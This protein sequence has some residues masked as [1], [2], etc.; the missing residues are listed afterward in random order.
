MS[1]IMLRN[2]ERQAFKTCRHR[3]QWTYLDGRQAAS[4]PTALRFGDLIHQALAVYYKPGRKRGPKPAGTFERLYHEQAKALASQGF[5]VF[6]DEKWEP[7]LDLGIA[8]LEGYVVEYA[9]QDKEY[10]VI[11]SEQTFQLRIRHPLGFTFYIV[12]TFDGLWR[13]LRTKRVK[14]KEFK[15]AAAIK[16]DGLPMDEQASTYWTYGPKWLKQKGLLQPGQMPAEILYTFLRK[17]RRDPEATYNAQG[18]KLNLPSKAVLQEG[19]F[20]KT[21]RVA[22][23][24]ATV[25]DLIDAI[26]R[27]EA[28]LL[29]EVSKTQPAPFFHREPVYRDEADR[30]RQHNR[31][32]VEMA[33]IY[34]ARQP[35]A[36]ILQNIKNPGPLHM[37][38]CLGCAVREACELHEAGGDFTS[39]LNATMIQWDPYAAHELP[40]RH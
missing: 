11:S 19:Y 36:D 26:G 25:Q 10:E 15:T 37:P 38:N 29:G 17:A 28:L 32:M 16:T 7:A 8:M 24:K 21:G 5:N 6:S 35:E 22:D 2:S 12:G 40:E 33:S 13:H 27:Q 23:K 9:E 18:H 20:R 1:R 14:F 3:W 39:V 31:I 34:A 30:R 4:A